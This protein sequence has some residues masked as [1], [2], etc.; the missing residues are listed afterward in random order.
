M[1]NVGTRL[2]KKAKEKLFYVIEI[3]GEELEAIVYLY[4]YF[5]IIVTPCIIYLEKL[6]GYVPL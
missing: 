2:L 6:A 4:K 3:E 5:I 1:G